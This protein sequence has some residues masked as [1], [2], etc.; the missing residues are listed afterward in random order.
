VHAT[1]NLG[2]LVREWPGIP[3][4]SCCRFATPVEPLAYA[5]GVLFHA[6]PPQAE[7]DS[8]TAGGDEGAPPS[9]CSARPGT[10]FGKKRLLLLL[11]LLCA[12]GP[13]YLD[14][15]Y[16]I[17]A[18]LTVA[19]RRS[20]EDDLVRHYLDE[21]RAAGAARG[22]DITMPTPNEVRLGIRLGVLY[23]FYHWGITV[24]VDR[25]ITGALLHRLGT[26]V[27]DHDAYAAVADA[28]SR[29]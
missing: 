16:H 1:E 5:L 13:W 19:D 21:L 14:V 27:A 23:G 28:R 15:G 12:F 10:L 20:R 6:E 24:M 8:A 4:C 11:S 9:R 18:A 25:P 26:A 2:L 17:A 29:A 3:D 22:T 7:S